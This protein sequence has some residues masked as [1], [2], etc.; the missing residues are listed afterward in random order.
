M[1]LHALR[2]VM[3][4]TLCLGWRAGSDRPLLPRVRHQ[5]SLAGCEA[6]V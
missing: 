1:T 3:S 6:G 2:T 4:V 5:L